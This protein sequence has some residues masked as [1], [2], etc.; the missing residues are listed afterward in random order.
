MPFVYFQPKVNNYCIMTILNFEK[1]INMKDTR[2]KSYWK[3][4]I[5]YMMHSY[6]TTRKI[7]NF[8]EKVTVWKPNLY[9]KHKAN[10]GIFIKLS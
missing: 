1:K 10:G 4:E 8:G 9:H 2:S 7:L 5:K 3:L 6:Y